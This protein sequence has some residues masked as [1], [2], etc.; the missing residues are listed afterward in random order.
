M[1]GLVNI[2]VIC[3][4]M[5]VGLGMLQVCGVNWIF[6]ASFVQKIIGKCDESIHPLAQLIFGWVLANQG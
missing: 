3:L 6:C 1:V 4:A 5:T 2:F